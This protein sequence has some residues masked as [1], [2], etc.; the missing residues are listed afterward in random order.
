MNSK[1]KYPRHYERILW[2][3]TKADKISKN[4]AINSENWKN[5]LQIKL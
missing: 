4:R 3:Y 2:N 1:I 5:V